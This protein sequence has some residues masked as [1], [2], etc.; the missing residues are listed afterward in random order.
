MTILTK[1]I[2]PKWGDTLLPNVKPMPST[3]ALCYY[4]SRR[5][6]RPRRCSPCFKECMSRRLPLVDTEGSYRIAEA[7]RRAGII[8]ETAAASTSGP[9]AIAMTGTFTVVIS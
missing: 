7:A 8:P 6:P 2:R 1:H 4:F 9:M 3:L 5:R